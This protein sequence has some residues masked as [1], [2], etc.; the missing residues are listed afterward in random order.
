[1]ILASRQATPWRHYPDDGP[2]SLETLRRWRVLADARAR[3]K[4]AKRACNLCKRPINQWGYVILRP[5][6]YRAKPRRR[7]ICHTCWT[8]LVTLLDSLET[9]GQLDNLPPEVLD[10]REEETP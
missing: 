9:S 2:A 7:Y 10:Y 1:M 8:T 6:G 4:G 3:K 5:I